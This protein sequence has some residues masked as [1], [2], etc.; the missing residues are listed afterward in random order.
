MTMNTSPALPTDHAARMER[1]AVALDGL[2]VGDAI[3]DFGHY[4]GRVDFGYLAVALLLSLG[5]QLC[6]AHG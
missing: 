1:A 6:R 2:S 5:L 3:G 4:L